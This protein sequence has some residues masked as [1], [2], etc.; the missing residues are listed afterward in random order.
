MP[1]NIGP[2]EIILVLAIALLVLGPGKLPEV[3]ASLG[4]TIREF[5]KAS[6][7]VTDATSLEAPKTV[8]T[9]RS[10]ASATVVEPNTLSDSTEPN[11]LNEST[12]ADARRRDAASTARPVGDEA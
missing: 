11:R 8:V 1:F 6:S 4:K 7:E 12:D 5:R 2:G 10:A 3:G 9:D